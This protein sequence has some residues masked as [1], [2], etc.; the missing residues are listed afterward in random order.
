M[1][2]ANR[3]GDQITL[4]IVTPHRLLQFGEPGLQGQQLLC[5]RIWPACGAQRLM[6]F[7]LLKRLADDT[8]ALGTRSAARDLLEIGVAAEMIIAEAGRVARQHPAHRTVGRAV[9]AAIEFCLKGVL[10]LDLD[11][12]IAAAGPDVDPHRVDVDH[13]LDGGKLR[14]GVEGGHGTQIGAQAAGHLGVASARMIA[15]P[16]DQAACALQPDGLDQF[17]PKFCEQAAVGQQHALLVEPDLA[18]PGIEPDLIDE[19]PA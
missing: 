12:E 9:A 10:P 3:I 14:T 7:P 8:A 2:A 11:I 15:E 5:Q 19:I 1:R 18:R 16:H 17:V 6:I 4:P 13:A